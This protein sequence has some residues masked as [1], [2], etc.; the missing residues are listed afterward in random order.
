VSGIFISYR[1][2]DSQSAAGRLADFL[3]RSFGREQ[4]FRDVET[5][6]PG[7]DF[8]H[9]IDRAIVSSKVMLVIIGPRWLTIADN[10]GQRR[11]LKPNDWIRIETA[12]ALKRDLRVIPVLVENATPPADA[13]LPDDIKGL[14]RR[15]AHELSDKRWDYDVQQLVEALERI[16]GI[17]RRT[18]PPTPP[19]HEHDKPKPPTTFLSKMVK[20]FAWIGGIFV[21]LIVLGLILNESSTPQPGIHQNIPQNVPAL[22]SSGVPVSPCGCWGPAMQGATAPNPRCASGTG[23]AMLCSGACPAGGSPWQA[24]CR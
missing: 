7:V 10:D 19:L 6:E 20:T 23:V 17:R 24:I 1:R 22:I 5:I 15:E 13:D 16:P 2:H 21:A 11:L 12:S 18:P 4:I 8:V 14:A 9:A 3:E